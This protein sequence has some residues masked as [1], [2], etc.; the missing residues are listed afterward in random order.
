MHKLIGKETRHAFEFLW[1]FT[2]CVFKVSYIKTI[3]KEIE[4]CLICIH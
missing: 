2:F 3:T 1:I 4:N